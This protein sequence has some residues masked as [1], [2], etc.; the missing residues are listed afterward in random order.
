MKTKHIFKVQ[1]PLVSSHECPPALIYN[2]DRSILDEVPIT[3]KLRALFPE[4]VFKIY[5]HGTIDDAGVVDLN[6]VVGE[7]EW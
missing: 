4:D 3:S 7:Q 6:E 2:E 5:V 1:I